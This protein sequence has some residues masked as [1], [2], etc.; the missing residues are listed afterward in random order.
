M[1]VYCNCEAVA[2]CLGGIFKLTRHFHSIYFVWV[3]MCHQ[4]RLVL[5]GRQNLKFTPRGSRG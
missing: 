5:R 1:H 4:D 2:A 3:L